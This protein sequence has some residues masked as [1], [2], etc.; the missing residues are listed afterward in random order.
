[1]NKELEPLAREVRKFKSAGE[2]IKAR[3]GLRQI[4]PWQEKLAKYGIPDHTTFY[5]QATKGVKKIKPEIKPSKYVYLLKSRAGKSK[6]QIEKYDTFEDAYNKV[7]FYY[8]SYG[9]ETGQKLYK[10]GARIVSNNE[11]I[12][13]LKIVR[14]ATKGELKN[15]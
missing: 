14:I 7:K 2:F 1:M 11:P 12:L 4:E 9:G 3:M 8:E 15:E 10:D 5:S 6:T 13:V